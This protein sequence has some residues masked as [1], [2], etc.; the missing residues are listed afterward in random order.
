MD[1][2]K[3]AN[4]IYYYIVISKME[5]DDKIM[6]NSFD[7]AAH[8]YG[9]QSAAFTSVATTFRVCDCIQKGEPWWSNRE[10][11]RLAIDELR[12]ALDKQENDK[13]YNKKIH[14]SV[15]KLVDELGSNE[16]FQKMITGIFTPPV[17]ISEKSDTQ[18]ELEKL[19]EECRR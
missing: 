17:F 11:E 14:E 4:K 6:E 9:V 1:N 19:L 5:Y 10:E 2:T 3:R 13:D 15:V 7:N 18:D 16:N 8:V 12:A